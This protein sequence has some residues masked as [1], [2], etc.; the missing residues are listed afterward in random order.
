MTATMSLT[1]G[2]LVGGHY[3][4]GALINRGGFGAVYRGVDTSEGNR[5]CAIKETYDVTPAA[6]R[7]AL[8]EAAVLFT[9]D[10][11]HLPK[12]YDAFEDNGR[13][14][15]VMQL[16]EGQ[17]LLE[18]MR[19]RGAPCSEQETL[20]WLLPIAEVLHE[21][22]SRRPAIM[23][24]DI[25][26]GNIIIS[27]AQSAVLVDFG[28]TKLYDP[29]VDTQ[30]SVR[31]VSEGFSP[32]E[33]YLGKTSPQSDIYS[34]AATMYYLLTGYV[35]PAAMQRSV[36]ETLIPPRQLNPRISPHVEQALMTALA[37]NANNRY[38]SMRDFIAALQPFQSPQQQLRLAQLPQPSAAPQPTFNDAD[39][40]FAGSRIDSFSSAAQSPVQADQP[41]SITSTTP[42]L[43]VSSIAQ[44]PSQAPQSPPL[45]RSWSARQE[46]GKRT[47]APGAPVY[48]VLPPR[49]KVAQPAPVGP[50]YKSLPNPINQGCLWGMLQGI[51]SALLVLST[52]ATTSLKNPGTVYVAIV[53]GLFFYVV[54]GFFTTHKGGIALRGIWAGLWGGISS[55]A[56]FWTVFVIGL[57]IKLEPFLKQNASNS[58]PVNQAN[59][60]WQKFGIDIKQV[61]SLLFNHSTTQ[62][63]NNSPIVYLAVGLICAMTAGLLGGIL[64]AA[65]L[66]ARMRK[67][68]YI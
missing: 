5:P 50:T 6:R 23:H 2:A 33:Q 47:N 55:T 13:F 37:Q 54:A 27:P 59:D 18:I 20:G 44:P 46:P 16:I 39:R 56:V 42:A 28:L 62:Q 68:G 40:T 66:R 24:R 52:I 9:I 29:N 57:I 26:P 21:L 32:I 35:A 10:S 30:T 1:P 36:R 7:Q 65:R 19:Q 41:R 4:V 53:M 14:Y 25:K 22:H 48:P 31:A 61:T 67:K 34:L 38:D 8:M 64:G 3:V 58:S 49:P 11:D 63:N 43:P 60:F 17:N 12:V 15:L 45:P 51:L